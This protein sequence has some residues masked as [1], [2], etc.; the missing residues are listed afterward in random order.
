MN[1]TVLHAVVGRNRYPVESWQQVSEAYTRTIEAL[2]LGASRV[3]NCRIE[4]QHGNVQAHVSY[5][6]RVWRGDGARLTGVLLYDPR[7]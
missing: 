7:S 1:L 4:D 6:G 3:P 2:G 5:N